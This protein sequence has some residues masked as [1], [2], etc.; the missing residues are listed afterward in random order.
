MMASVSFFKPSGSHFPHFPIS[1]SGRFP[2]A[3]PP[4]TAAAGTAAPARALPLDPPSR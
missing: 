2:T 1:G 3:P 4:P